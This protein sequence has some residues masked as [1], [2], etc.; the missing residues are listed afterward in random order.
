MSNRSAAIPIHY[1]SPVQETIR[2]RQLPLRIGVLIIDEGGI[3]MSDTV[4]GGYGHGHGYG[5][6]HGGGAAFAFVIFI[7]LVIILAAGIW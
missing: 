3:A 2:Q 1:S 6:G 4:H 5:Y 7:L